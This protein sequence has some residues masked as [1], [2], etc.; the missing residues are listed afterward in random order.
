MVKYTCSILSDNILTKVTGVAREIK[1][2]RILKN[3][4]RF[5]TSIFEKKNI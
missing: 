5:L 4:I 3:K 1:K 2:N